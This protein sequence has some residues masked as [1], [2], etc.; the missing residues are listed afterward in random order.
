MERLDTADAPAAIGPY[1]QGIVAGDLIVTAGQIG[2]DPASGRL[3]EGGVE[4]QTERVMQN[5]AAVLAAAGVG[6]DAVCRSTIYLTDLGA[7]QAV[8]AVYARHLGDHRPAR[9][10]VGVAALPLGAQVLIDMMA[11]RPG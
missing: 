10:T 11:V 3:V 5:L 8:N 6:L 9:T 2:L 7:F 1:S 4:A